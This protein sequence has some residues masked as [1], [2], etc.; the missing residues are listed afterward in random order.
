MGVYVRIHSP[1]EPL[2]PEPE[3]RLHGAHAG[4]I[5]APFLPSLDVLR[6]VLA[7]LLAVHATAKEIVSLIAPVGWSTWNQRT[8]ST[9]W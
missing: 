8:K 9:V 7:A 2:H 4:D 1:H 3:P 6:L 5:V